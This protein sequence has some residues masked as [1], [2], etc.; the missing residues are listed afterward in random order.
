[1]DNLTHSFVG[2]AV[3]KA[4]LERASPLATT[5][6]VLAA[7]AAD[8]DVLT[9]FF[10]SRWIVLRYHRGVT[11]SIVGTVALGFLIPTIILWVM[12]ELNVCGGHPGL[13]VPISRW[14]DSN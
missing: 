10:G 6:C 2:L 11:H 4:G 1:M 7:N 3:A 9:G 5:V 13:T 8:A 14:G 12:E